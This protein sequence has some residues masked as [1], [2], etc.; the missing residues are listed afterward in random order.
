MPVQNRI[1]FEVET[2]RGCFVGMEEGL[3]CYKIYSYVT[4]Y[5]VHARDFQFIKE[6]VEKIFIEDGALGEYR[7]NT[8]WITRR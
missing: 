7:E 3:I 8:M 5:I 1:K 6:P 4:E 2:E